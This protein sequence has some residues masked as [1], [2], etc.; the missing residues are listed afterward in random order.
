MN[1][2]SELKKNILGK[3]FYLKQQQKGSEEYPILMRVINFDTN[4]DLYR[5]LDMDYGLNKKDKQFIMTEVELID[6]YVAIAPHGVIKLSLYTS[7]EYRMNIFITINP[8]IRTC[9]EDTIQY[10]L[11]NFNVLIIDSM[12]ELREHG[13][14]APYNSFY[15]SSTNVNNKDIFVTDTNNNT[16]II[17]DKQLLN[18]N[19]KL[20]DTF[21]IY[22]YYYDDYKTMDFIKECPY[23]LNYES[24]LKSL[25]DY[26]EN[27][28]MF[29]EKNPKHFLPNN[30]IYDSLITPVYKFLLSETIGV[31]Y[32]SK[33]NFNDL[34]LNSKNYT[35]STET[36]LYLFNSL[37][38]DKQIANDLEPLMNHIL[39]SNYNY[40]TPTSNTIR[41]SD[42]DIESIHACLFDPINE[43]FNDTVEEAKIKG[44]NVIMINIED[45]VP[46]LLYYKE[47]TLEKRLD[48]EIGLNKAE[49]SQF[50]ANAKRKN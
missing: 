7:A 41:F 43:S 12:K 18:D 4:T 42:I 9:V 38:S 50:L 22:Y 49:V 1:N 23:L 14:L 21:C 15:I 46:I 10:K 26:K 36:I 39:N 6:N 27:R 5:C 2:G 31:K 29:K 11:N 24:I 8:Y 33:E 30:Y 37:N 45:S 20:I 40:L 28:Y 25:T 44:F 48:K 32:I 3:I 16:L 17:K 13:F 47:I 35:F 34:L 19:I